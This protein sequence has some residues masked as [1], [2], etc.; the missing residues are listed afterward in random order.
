MESFAITLV[1]IAGRAAKTKHRILFSVIKI[2]TVDE[3]RVLVLLEVCHAHDRRVG[4]K[5]RGYP[6]STFRETSNKE[7][8]RIFFADAALDLAHHIL[9]LQI[10]ITNQSHR[11]Y[12]DV[13]VDD[14]LQAS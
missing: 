13:V 3:H 9:T 10:W 12:A 4:I 7:I 6:V 5:I 14:E 11:M 2:L 8:A 1:V